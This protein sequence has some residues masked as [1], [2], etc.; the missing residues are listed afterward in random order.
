MK[1]SMKNGRIVVEE[2]ILTKNGVPVDIVY[3][4]MRNFKRHNG[5]L[6]VDEDRLNDLLRRGLSLEDIQ[7]ILDDEI[8]EILRWEEYCEYMYVLQYGCKED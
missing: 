3:P 8:N 4:Y 7:S 6:Y 5:K 1:L 2:K